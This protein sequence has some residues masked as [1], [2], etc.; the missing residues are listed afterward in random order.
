MI[1]IVGLEDDIIGFG[2]AGLNRM[3]IITGQETPDELSAAILSLETRA[4]IIPGKIAN[5][6]RGRKELA[7]I[8]LIDIPD[9]EVGSERIAK[10]ARE[11]LGVDII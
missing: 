1:G 10:L 4:V 11:L 2:L 7:H 3:S 5:M 6:V 8:F 9:S